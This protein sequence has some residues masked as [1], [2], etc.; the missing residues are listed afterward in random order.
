LLK[1]GRF[2]ISNMKP[3]EERQ[4][5]FT[6]DVHSTLKDSEIKVRLSVGD[7]DLR[8]FASEKLELPVVDSRRALVLKK[9]T[10][11]RETARRTA[12]LA[13]PNSRALVLGHLPEGTALRV[14][15]EYQNFVQVRLAE[16]RF[17]FIPAS[18]LRASSKKPSSETAFEPSLAHSPPLLEVS[19]PALSTRKDS[20]TISA[21]ATD[22]SG[23]VED[24]FAFVG[25]RKVYYE[26]NRSKDKKEMKISFDA[27]LKPGVNVITVVARQ[28]TD[29]ATQKTIV[30]RRDGPNGEALP[31]PKAELLGG[32]W[33]FGE[34]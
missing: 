29:T 4:V 17:G 28:N 8:V 31:T 2:D 24:A 30:V 9:L 12:L 25:S 14:M 16:E 33:E 32:D 27:P 15:G 6:F 5:Q 7:R 13:E 11:V 18:E 23:G 19:A 21:R 3:G 26:L 34:Q 10:E 1:A 20:I 22:G